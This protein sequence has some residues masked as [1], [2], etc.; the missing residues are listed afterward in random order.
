MTPSDFEAL[1]VQLPKLTKDQMSDLRRRVLF[2]MGDIG[3]VASEDWV[4]HG[5]MTVAQERGVGHMIP[6]N[7]RV[8]KNRSFASYETQA[9]RVRVLL[10]DAIPKMTVTE[11]R[12]L[13]VLAARALADHISGWSPI[14]FDALMRNVA[15]IPEAIDWAYPGYIESGMLSLVLPSRRAA[16]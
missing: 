12:G 5:I 13:G 2:L 8:R 9:D 15:K 3:N 6:P 1:V 7:F 10:S 4:L 14:T 11:Q 16:E